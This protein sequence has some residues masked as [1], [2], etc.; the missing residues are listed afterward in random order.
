MT[1]ESG[2]RGAA[3]GD[4]GAETPADYIPEYCVW[5]LT[6][7]CNMRC[8][9]CGSRA[10]RARANELT[11]DE[12]LPVA[13]EL[14]ALG[15][16]QVTFIGGE[17]FLYEGWE[18]VARR[19]ADGG[20]DVNVITNGWLMGPR[21]L[22]Q[23]REGG[24]VNVGVSIDG[25]QKNHDYIRRIKGSYPRS[26]AALEALRDAQIPTAVVTSLLGINVDDLEPL[27]DEL[28]ARGVNIWQIQIATPMGNLDTG[29][30]LLVPRERIPGVMAFIR[31]KRLEG[32]I[33]LYA[34]DDIGY[35]TEDE[36]YLRNRP[37]TLAAWQ[38]CQAGLRVV[39]IDSVGNVKGCESLYDDY[40]IEGNVRTASL[41]AIW[42]DPG[43]FAYNRA[44]DVAQLTGRCARCDKAARC[45]GGCR[46]S[47]YFNAERLYEN[48]YCCYPAAA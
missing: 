11:V 14:L 22:D 12:C 1:R 29:R 20:A 21:Q 24:L 26:L 9:H 18:K 33:R 45:R 43:N 17:V 5:E 30:D 41:A 42:T 37:G 32:R 23:I 6:L 4:P 27:Y 44:F 2:K 36:L 34:G 3:A 47:C 39:G 19:F 28:A 35:F 16:R 7:A 46:G 15:C 10:G 31:E 25:L 48:P 8:L 38:G 40:F 13:D